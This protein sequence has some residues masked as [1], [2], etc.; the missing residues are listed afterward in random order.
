MKKVLLLSLLSA[1]TANFVVSGQE[2]SGNPNSLEFMFE[3]L[4]TA[5]DDSIRLMINDSIKTVIG[6]YVRSDSVFGHAF[7]GVRSLG[8]ITSPDSRIKIITWNLVLNNGNGWYFCYLVKR[9]P[10][11]RDI[12][13]YRLQR[14]YSPEQIST[15]TTYSAS[16]WYGALY[17]DV[18]PCPYNGRQSWILLGI[19]YGDTLV[20]R[21]VID[22]LSFSASGTP[23]F[24]WKWFNTGKGVYYRY[25]VKYAS[26]GVV[27]LRF[28]SPH[29]IVFDHLEP[30]PPLANDGRIY[31]GSDYSFDSFTFKDGIWS[32]AMNIDVRN[33]RK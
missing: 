5:T 20:T 25:V 23:V 1:F 4:K 21:K 14:Q 3:R 32:L 33:K 22:V 6:N 10:K 19:N 16:D 31:F 15:D 27:S 9:N 30:V 11:N 24:G 28:S 8:Q 18:R 17:Y 12:A 2:S 26:N 29:T 13:V 7:R